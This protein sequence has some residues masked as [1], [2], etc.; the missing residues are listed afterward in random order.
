[1]RNVSLYS[2][3]YI[4]VNWSQVVVGG[5]RMQLPVPHRVFRFRWWCVRAF[6]G[7]ITKFNDFSV[8][9][10]PLSVLFFFRAFIFAVV[11]FLLWTIVTFFLNFPVP[12]PLT[13]FPER[14]GS[15]FVRGNMCFYVNSPFSFCSLTL[16]FLKAHAF[17][18]LCTSANNVD[19]VR[20]S[21]FRGPWKV[22][23]SP[24]T[25]FAVIDV[26][27]LMWTEERES[28]CSYS[29]VFLVFKSLTAVCS[30]YFSHRERMVPPSIHARTFHPVN[31]FDAIAFCRLTVALL[32]SDPK[33]FQHGLGC[34][35]LRA[36]HV[37][38][39]NKWTR[40]NAY[41]GYN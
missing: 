11:L 16:F 36:G 4:S 8:T 41:I 21:S 9:F 15:A 28:V 2:F 12:M 24:S 23:A 22:C 10:F 7:S 6:F 18:L 1:M 37:D 25:T 17:E 3:T 38:D 5:R 34:K 29:T 39:V 14:V 35:K 26:S 30:A 32:L 31:S 33:D 20:L 13:S 27:F 19:G 40:G